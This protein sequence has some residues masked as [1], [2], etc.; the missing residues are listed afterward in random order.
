MKK[1]KKEDKEGKEKG[2]AVAK[3]VVSE[4]EKGDTAGITQAIASLLKFVRWDSN[5]T[6]EVFE[7]QWNLLDELV[8][9]PGW[10]EAIGK[11]VVYGGEHLVTV[12]NV[13]GNF[14]KTFFPSR[15][16][17]ISEKRLGAMVQNN[18]IP[19]LLEVIS[20]VLK[21]T[22]LNE[23]EEV[24]LAKTTLL[25]LWSMA[26]IPEGKGALSNG[27]PVNL[28]I[29]LLIIIITSLIDSNEENFKCD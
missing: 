23:K 15:P 12:V 14:A 8:D 1:F 27:V 16:L 10:L 29:Y 6:D 17:Q 18:F 7:K 2:K 19:K 22:K 3:A 26:S 5:P 9:E 4:I 25:C 11:Y 28:F 20:Q 21:G 13:L 24:E